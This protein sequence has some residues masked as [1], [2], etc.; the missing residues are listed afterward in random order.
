MLFL[1]PACDT[2]PDLGTLLAKNH[3]QM[4]LLDPGSPKSKTC[5][6]YDLCRPWY[7]CIASRSEVRLG[8]LLSSNSEKLEQDLNLAFSQKF[9]TWSRIQQKISKTSLA[10]FGD[11]VGGNECLIAGDIQAEMLITM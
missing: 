10:I 8:T 7:C 1:S 4:W 9:V 5:L 6:T 11:L 2:L 3:H